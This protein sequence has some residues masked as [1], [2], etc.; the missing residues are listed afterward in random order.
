MSSA[1]YALGASA[2]TAGA[3]TS[4]APRRRGA[5]V[6]VVARGRAGL[7]RGGGFDAPRR[8]RPLRRRPRGRLDRWMTPR[9][10]LA[11]RATCRSSRLTHSQFVAQKTKDAIVDVLRDREGARPSVDR[12]DPDV[13]V[14]VRL[15]RDHATIYLDVG[16]ASL[17]ERGWRARGGT[18]PLRENLAAAVVRLSG[19][20]RHR[21]LLDP[22]CGS[23]TLAIEAATW[24]R[25]VAPGLAR[26]R[27]GFE[28]WASH[29]DPAK[30]GMGE[31]RQ[32]ARDAACPAARRP[33]C[34]PATST[35]TRSSDP[36]ERAPRRGRRDRRARRRA[37]HPPARAA[38]HRGDQPAVRRASRSGP[39]P[40]RRSRP[41]PPVAARSHDR[42][43]RRGAGD[44][45]RDGPKPDSWWALYR[46]PMNVACRLRDPADHNRAMR[47]AP[48]NDEARAV[49]EALGLAPHPE[50][51]SSARPS[52]RRWRSRRRRV[53][54]SASTAIY[55]LL[56]AGSFSAL[57]RVESDEV[58]HHYDGDPVE[59]YTLRDDGEAG[60]F[61]SGVT[62]RGAIDRR[63][64][65]PRASGRRR[66]RWASASPCAAAPSRRGSS[67]PTSSCLRGRGCSSDSP[68]FASSS[69]GSRASE[70]TVLEPRGELL[71]RQDARRGDF[72]DEATGATSLLPNPLLLLASWRLGGSL[73]VLG[74]LSARASNSGIASSRIPRIRSRPSSWSSSG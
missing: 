39:R 5:R 8:R 45:P 36:R 17:H 54:R 63:S 49:A 38:G 43:P 7:A 20:D 55:F 53:A 14:A 4:R 48:M 35:S 66:S 59:L 74:E 52:A 50:G 13:G 32:Q 64:S 3:C 40:L 22:M 16:G 11:V 34:A 58:W 51:A 19:W 65:S 57:H 60:S 12:D 61:A 44:R 70:L 42:A 31:Q 25:R 26:P 21:P 47:G 67:S 33:P 71:R 29:D 37:G 15:A 68:R 18:A 10:T 23:G 30:A 69:F 2:P 28:R 56:P 27:F 73:L 41:V 62:S 24:A 46:L 72:G 1:S 9:T 6:P